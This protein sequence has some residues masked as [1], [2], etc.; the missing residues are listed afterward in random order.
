MIYNIKLIPKTIDDYFEAKEE[1]KQLFEE[2]GLERIKRT[3][4]SPFP[5]TLQ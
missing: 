5:K 4:K 1:V 3:F 2:L